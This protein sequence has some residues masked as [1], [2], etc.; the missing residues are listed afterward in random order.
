LIYAFYL[1]PPSL[2][3]ATTYAKKALT[4]TQGTKKPEGVDDVAFKKQQNIQLG[5][6]H[7][8]L[9][10]VA[11]KRIE[12]TTGTLAPA[13]DELRTAANLLEGNPALQGQALYYLGNAYEM[14]VPAN[15]RAAIDALSRAVSLPGPMQGPARDLLAKVKTKV[16]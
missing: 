16:R 15:H 9:G 6:A 11:L 3:K 5:M 10:F 4:A 13:I 8:T 14:G 1:R 7:L 12:R 2:E